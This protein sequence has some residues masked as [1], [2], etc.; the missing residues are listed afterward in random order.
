MFWVENCIFLAF[1][2]L[3]EIVLIPI[4]YMKVYLNLLKA[5]FG[6]FTKVA[7][8]MIWAVMGLLILVLFLLRDFFSLFKI[9]TMHNG[10]QSFFKIAKI[11]EQEDLV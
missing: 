9:L 5:S 7:F 2:L 6:F 8:I 4:C 1:F 11:D 3:L 10:C